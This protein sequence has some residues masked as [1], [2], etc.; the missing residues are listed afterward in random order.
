MNAPFP[1]AHRSDEAGAGRDLIGYGRQGVRVSWPDDARIA[2]N[3]VI[4]Y[5][6]GAEYS[7][8]S[9]D[10]VSEP[11]AELGYPSVGH[12]LAT[13][14]IFDYGS[15][16]GIWRL[17]RLLD[18]YRLPA[19]FFGVARAFELNPE[20]GAYVREADHDVCCH[21]LRWERVDALS[22]EEERSRIAEA[23]DSI[24]ATCDTRPDGWYCRAPASPNTRE[25]LV[26]EGGFL[27]DSDSF[28][29]D[30]PYFVPVLGRQHLVVPYSFV[31][32]DSKFAPGQSFS[33]AGS[34]FDETRR[35]FDYLWRE[36]ESAPKMLTVGLHPRIIGQPARA[37][38][39]REFIEHA[40][41]H[42]H[43]WFARR[44]DIASWW[45]AAAL[46]TQGSGLLA[47][48]RV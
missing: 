33:S 26:E 38:A 42:D 16:A 22:R 46:G 37:S 44:R 39:L 25:L 12:D 36:G 34:F 32:N 41:G 20:V 9:G 24:A 13:E 23:V 7:V 28:A 27:Y 2:V 17:Q 5:E 47:E 11:P 8:A 6:E 35:A 30:V 18:E 1:P 3:L 40:L 15:R 48:E 19:T 43:V 29:D 4:N 21:G 45:Q 31:T 10:S 14:S